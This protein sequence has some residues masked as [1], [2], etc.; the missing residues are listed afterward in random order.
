[1]NN[2][3]TSEKG[4]PTVDRTIKK[5]FPHYNIY[6]MCTSLYNTAKNKPVQLPVS[7]VISHCITYVTELAYS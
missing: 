3:V 4:G 5:F 6:Y 2:Y 1:M 7:L